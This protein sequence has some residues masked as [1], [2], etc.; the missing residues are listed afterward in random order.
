MCN[1]AQQAIEQWVRGFEG[2]IRQLSDC[3]PARALHNHGVLVLSVV[4]GRL[5]E[6]TWFPYSPGGK[7]KVEREGEGPKRQA[8][9]LPD[10]GNA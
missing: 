9:R 6:G 5:E 4:G 2:P 1:A 7:R 10:G 8:L 3:V